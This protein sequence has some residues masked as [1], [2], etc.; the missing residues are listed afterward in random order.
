MHA[1]AITKSLGHAR[2]FMAFD[3]G[4]DA[5]GRAIHRDRPLENFAVSAFN[6]G[7][8]GLVGNMLFPLI[9][10]LPHQSDEYY[11]IEKDA[12][13]RLEQDGALRAKGTSARR[14][15]FTVSSDTYFAPN[16]ALAAEIP[17]E[18]LANADRAIPLRRHHTENLTMDLKRQQE[19]RIA[20]LVTSI[21]NV[22]SGV[23]LTGSAKWSD[24]AGSDP[25]ADVR[26]GQAF[27]RSQTGLLPNI[28]I[29][30]WD[31]VQILS[32]HPLLLEMHKYTSGG[33]LT[34]DQLAKAFQ[35]NT[36]GVAN[37][38][39]NVAPEGQTF[40]SQNIWNNCCVLAHVQPGVDLMTMTLGLRMGWRPEG[41]VNDMN[42][43]RSRY[44][45][46]GEPH[47]EV[48]ETGHYQDEKIV[49]RDLGYTITGAL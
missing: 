37:S 17:I 47:I 48:I 10:N 1:E 29:I 39:R 25:I 38:I 11:V 30:D 19:L 41:G 12:F 36:I 6:R 42:V 8:E 33:E 44:D 18:D 3:A 49:A 46:A 9:P 27:I 20:N 34:L 35:V 23:N 31:T 45:R 24:Y 32:R 4:A 26:T 43:I 2:K 13:L 28:A 14:K 5:S 15:G 7:T 16:Y 21:S 40:S 22:G